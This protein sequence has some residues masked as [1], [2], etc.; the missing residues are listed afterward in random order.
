VVDPFAQTVCVYRPLLEG[1]LAGRF[2][3]GEC[4]GSYHGP[5]R[6]ATRVLEGLVVDTDRLFAE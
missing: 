5:A 6:V 2:D 1:A 3:R 4:C